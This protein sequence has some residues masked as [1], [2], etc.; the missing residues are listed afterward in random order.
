MANKF[1]MGA[2]A[3]CIGHSEN[4][5]PIPDFFIVKMVTDAGKTRF[6]QF[7]E[8]YGIEEKGKWKEVPSTTERCV[9][10]DDTVYDD[11]VWRV[12][13]K[14]I[15]PEKLV[16]HYDIEDITKL[17]AENWAY[18]IRTN[19]AKSPYA[20]NKVLL[21][22]CKDD[23][24]VKLDGRRQAHKPIIEAMNS[25]LIKEKESKKMFKNNV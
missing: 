21:E 11:P 22:M 17:V 23:A 18:S 5:Y 25:Y 8:K 14:N 2:Y 10:L 6:F 13:G 20:N 7:H 15:P 4:G 3:G 19:N 24:G 12:N 16:K 9:S 1:Y